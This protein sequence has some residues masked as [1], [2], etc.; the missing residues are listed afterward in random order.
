MRST[1]MHSAPDCRD[2]VTFDHVIRRAHASAVMKIE[3]LHHFRLHPQ[4]PLASVDPAKRLQIATWIRAFALRWYNV[5]AAAEA[6]EECAPLGTQLCW[7]NERGLGFMNDKPPGHGKCNQRL[8]CPRCPDQKTKIINVEQP[9]GR[10][11]ATHYCPAC[12]P[13]NHVHVA[14]G[15]GGNVKGSFQPGGFA[16]KP[17]PDEAMGAHGHARVPG[18]V[19]ERPLCRHD[20]DGCTHFD[21]LHELSFRHPTRE[22][23]GVTVKPQLKGKGN[24]RQT[25][26]N[27]FE[28]ALKRA[29]VAG[30]QGPGC[31]VSTAIEL[32][33]SD[34]E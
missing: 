2:H 1:C 23:P 16:G 33:D 13:H 27:F 11:R 10:K 31:S 19:D 30:T 3:A 32:S 20:R 9:D 6:R 22:G 8:R 15:A 34:G 5:R 18:V 21:I 4:T 12:Q 17:D 7:L 28:P 29:K 25:K 26:L 14:R 24:G